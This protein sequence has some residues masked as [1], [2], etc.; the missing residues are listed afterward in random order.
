MA[1]VTASIQLGFDGKPPFEGKLKP[2]GMGGDRMVDYVN[3]QTLSDPPAKMTRAVAHM[4]P[5]NREGAD[6]HS[7]IGQN[8]RATWAVIGPAYDDYKS[9]TV[10]ELIGTPVE[11]WAELGQL[12]G[13]YDLLK[14]IGIRT[15]EQ[16]RD[17]PDVQISRVAIP[18]RLG[19]RAKAGRYLELSQRTANTVVQD[20]TR[21]EVAELKSQVEM[22]MSKLAEMQVAS[23]DAPRRRGR[24]PRD[25]A[26]AEAA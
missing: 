12:E 8:V 9:K 6:P 20:A 21:S 14:Q 19:W 15:I 18:D 26:A 11:T 17:A 3:Y 13:A 25:D 23:E 10:R 16:L 22:L 24:P 1:Q 4:R 5:D 2:D 7:Y